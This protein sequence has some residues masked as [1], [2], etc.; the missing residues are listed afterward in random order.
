MAGKCA[1]SIDPWDG[2]QGPEAFICKAPKARKEHQCHECG[3]IITTGE[4]YRCESGIWDGRPERYKT[5]MDCASVRDTFFCSFLFGALW[6]QF[7]EHTS[8]C[9]GK[10]APECIAQ[11]TQAAKAKVLKVIG[12]VR[13]EN[14]G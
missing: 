5:C 11:L 7:Q 8:D 13:R 3:R 4:T 1:C 9:E 12:K 6:D 14:R 10:Y 2:D